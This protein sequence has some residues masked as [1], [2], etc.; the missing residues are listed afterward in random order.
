LF[1]GKAAKDITGNMVFKEITF[2]VDRTEETQLET[3]TKLTQ[4]TSGFEFL[5]LI[6]CM[7]AL[8]LVTLLR[9]G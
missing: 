4:S 7:V 3:T 8:C 1:P 9:N 2:T 5:P 6:L